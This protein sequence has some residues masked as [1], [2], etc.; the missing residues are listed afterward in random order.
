MVPPWQPRAVMVRGTAASARAMRKPCL[1][2][3]AIS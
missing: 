3:Y 2:R 1:A